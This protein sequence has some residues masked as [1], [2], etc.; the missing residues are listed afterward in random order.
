MKKLFLTQT[1]EPHLV[2]FEV[3]FFKGKL[4]PGSTME[5]GERFVG[6]YHPKKNKVFFTDVNDQEWTFIVDESCRII[7]TI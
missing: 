7:E 4:N 6:E 1:N 5:A 3:I 2:I